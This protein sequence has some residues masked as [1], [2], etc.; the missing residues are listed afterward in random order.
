MGS[1]IFFGG[2]GE[3]RET[4]YLLKIV[5][6]FLHEVLKFKLQSPSK[7]CP[8]DAIH[9]SRHFFHCSKQFLYSLILMPFSD[10]ASF[11]FT[12]STSAKH[13]PLMICF[14]QG[15][16]QKVTW[17]EIR[18]IGRVGHGGHCHFLSKTAE[19]SE[20]CGLVCL[21]ITHCKMGKCIEESSK[22]IHWSQTQPLTTTPASILIWMSS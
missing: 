13:F 19:H 6:L 1:S 2:G 4:I 7:Y 22:K 12:S 18:W 15:N 3:Q 5:Y 20:K 11:C 21:Y 10:S 8:V 9:L 17:G 14:H 16:K